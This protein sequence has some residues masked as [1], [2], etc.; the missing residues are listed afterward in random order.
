M[1]SRTLA[2]LAQLLDS[3]SSVGIIGNVSTREATAML[4]AMAE[5]THKLPEKA[6]DEAVAQLIGSY[7]AREVTDAKTLTKGIKSLFGAYPF[8]AVQRVINPV[9][10]LPSRLKF[11][12]TLAEIREALDAEMI[13]RGRIARNCKHII[14]AESK[15]IEDHEFERNRLPAEERARRVKEIL[16]QP[17]FGAIQPEPVNVNDPSLSPEEVARRKQIVIDTLGYD[18]LDKFKPTVKRE[19]TAPTDDEVR[20]L[21]IKSP[22][23]PASDELKELLWRQGYF[24]TTKQEETA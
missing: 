15:A 6:L 16:S 13:R 14:D 11:F 23:A 5:N 17:F 2:A 20:G 9:T 24:T 10:G 22:A 12:P 4:G 8:Y 7:P 3:E 19:R 21:D 18:P 1:P